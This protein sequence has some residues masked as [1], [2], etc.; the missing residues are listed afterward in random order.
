MLIFYQMIMFSIV[1]PIATE[2]TFA[3]N[4]LILEVSKLI[5]IWHRFT[6]IEWTVYWFDVSYN[7]K[8]IM[9]GNIFD[10]VIFSSVHYH[11]YPP[12]EPLGSNWFQLFSSEKKNP[13]VAGNVP[14]WRL[15]HFLTRIIPGSRKGRPLVVLHESKSNLKVYLV[16]KNLTLLVQNKTCSSSSNNGLSGVVVRD[17][18]QGQNL[19]PYISTL[20]SVTFPAH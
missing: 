12:K 19:W 18:L 17:P 8:C 6:N 1:F 7:I 15:Y 11:Q 14:K 10:T 13:K 4:C 16:Y 5:S 2:N 3:I 9:Y 20:I